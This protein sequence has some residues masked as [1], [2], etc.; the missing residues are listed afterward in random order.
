MGCVSA[1]AAAA[2][3]LHEHVCSNR[4]NSDN[5]NSDTGWLDRANRDAS[6]SSLMNVTLV[7]VAP[8]FSFTQQQRNQSLFANQTD[9]RSEEPA[10]VHLRSLMSLQKVATG[11]QKSHFNLQKRSERAVGS[12]QPMLQEEPITSQSMSPVLRLQRFQHQ[13]VILIRSIFN[14][15]KDF[16]KAAI[17]VPVKIFLRRLVHSDGFWYKGLAAAYGRKLQPED[18]YR[19]KLASMARGFDDD[20]FRFVSAQQTKLQNTSKSV[21][22]SSGL[23]EEEQ[24][25]QAGFPSSNIVP[26]VT[27]LDLLVS[28]LDMGCKVVII[29][30]TEDK[31][32]PLKSSQ[33]MAKLINRAMRVKDTSKEVTLISLEGFGHVPHEEDEKI[34]LDQMEAVGVNL[35]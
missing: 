34:F 4:N 24:E 14:H 13:S 2:V 9:D 5:S 18:I 11:V 17:K 26:G 29:H 25:I 30:G 7:L 20:L 8:A 28:L 33:L 19:Y 35:R 3:V 21:I 6:P 16:F 12:V 22:P 15:L 31:I 23:A 27:Q 10:V 32:V 1:M